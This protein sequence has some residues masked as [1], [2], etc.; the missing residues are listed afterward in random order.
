[1]HIEIAKCLVLFSGHCD[2]DLDLV[3]RIIVSGAYLLY[4]LRKES[5]IWYLEESQIWYLANP[6]FG[7]W[8][9]L[10]MTKRRASSL[11]PCDIDLDL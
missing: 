11:G 10:E 3:F 1:M 6:K 8:R 2:L 4:Y 5:K 7:I 9:H